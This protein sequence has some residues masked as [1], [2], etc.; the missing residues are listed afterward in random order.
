MRNKSLAAVLAFAFLD[1]SGAAA[2]DKTGIG[3]CDTMLRKYEQ[4]LRGVTLKKCAVFA[5]KHNLSKTYQQPGPAGEAVGPRTYASPAHACLAEVQDLIAEMRVNVQIMNKVTSGRTR[6]EACRGLQSIISHN[7]K[8][9][10][11]P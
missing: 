2:F 1:P 5:K 4:C 7:T 11:G 6:E 9:Y 10:C 8:S 3:W